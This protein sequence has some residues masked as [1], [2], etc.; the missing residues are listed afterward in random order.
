MMSWVTSKSHETYNISNGW[1]SIAPVDAGQDAK[2][3]LFGRGKMVSQ[4]T[5]RPPVDLERVDRL[6]SADG[7]LARDHMSL[8]FGA[9]RRSR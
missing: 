6:D 3:G 2:R 7:L 8:T 1:V 4:L 9:S 5:M